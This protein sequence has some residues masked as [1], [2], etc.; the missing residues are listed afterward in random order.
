MQ[1]RNSTIQLIALM[2]LAGLC[3]LPF[4][5]K[6]V[7]YDNI[8]FLKYTQ[9]LTFNPARCEVSDY[10]FQGMMLKDFVVFE[11][12]HPPLIPMWIKL[13]TAVLGDNAV[14]LQLRFLPFLWLACF[15]FGDLVQRLTGHS[16]LFAAGVILGPLFFPSASTLMAD[17][18]LFA[19]FTAALACWSRALERDRLGIWDMFTALSAFCA[20]F[21]AYQGLGLIPLLLI[22]GFVR[23]PGHTDQPHQ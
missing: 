2:L 9:R 13:W 16:P 21:T 5:N 20:C 7:T 3:Y 19:F 4:L 14:L 17:V 11:S 15:G 6:G 1:D 18:P 12:T 8:I 10:L 23:K 22:M